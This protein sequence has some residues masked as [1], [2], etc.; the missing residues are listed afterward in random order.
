MPYAYERPMSLVVVKSPTIYIEGIEELQEAL[1]R[2]KQ[3]K[4][5]WED[6]FRASNLEKI[7]LQKQLKENNDLI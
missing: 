7:E 5:A 4:D 6:K 1:D 2:M 3:K